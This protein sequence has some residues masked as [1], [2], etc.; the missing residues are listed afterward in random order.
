MQTEGSASGRIERQMRR[1][2]SVSSVSGACEKRQRSPAEQLPAWKYRH[3][4]SR[5]RPDATPRATRC[6]EPRDAMRR[7]DTRRDEMPREEQRERERSGE[8]VEL[9]KMPISALR[10]AAVHCA[11]T[12]QCTTSLSLCSTALSNIHMQY[13]NTSIQS[14]WRVHICVSV[15]YVP[16]SSKILYSNQICA[17]IIG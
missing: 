14:F 12:V 8:G 11:G 16:A 7:H 4:V 17:V 9:R 3:G 6:H 5:A 2:R 1:Q 15:R 13:I 10:C